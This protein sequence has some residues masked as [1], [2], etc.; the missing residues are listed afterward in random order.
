MSGTNLFGANFDTNVE[1][2]LVDASGYAYFAKCTGTPPTTA[3]LYQKGCIMIQ[4]NATSA[5]IFTNTGSLAS[6]VW[7]L[8]G[9]DATTQSLSGAGAVDVVSRVTNVTST[10]VNALT[11]ANGTAGQ[12]KTIVMIVD[13]G[14]ATLTPTNLLNGT[15][16]TFNDVGDS[17]EL[18]FTGGEWVFIGGTATLA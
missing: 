8:A 17:A 2:A 16:I 4:T 11:L 12:R 7:S 18:V 3:N 6:P 10:G 14:D 13:G 9:Q 1:A 5:G 15:T